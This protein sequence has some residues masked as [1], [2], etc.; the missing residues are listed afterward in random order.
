MLSH[1]VPENLD[2]AGFGHRVVRVIPFL[3]PVADD[4]DKAHKWVRLVI[5]GYFKQLIERLNQPVIVI[6]V[7]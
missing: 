5:A 6:F 2:T 7:F 4:V 1:Q 3:N